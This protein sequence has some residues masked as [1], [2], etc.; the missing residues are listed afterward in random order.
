MTNPVIRVNKTKIFSAALLYA[1]DPGAR[2]P[3]IFLV[4][5]TDSRVF[6]CQLVTDDSAAVFR[7]V[8]HQ[9]NFK[10]PER[11]LHNGTDTL[12]YVVFRSVDRNDDTDLRH[13]IPSRIL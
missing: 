5:Y 1:P 10:V 3:A 9:Y 2:E 12:F 6:S 11:L 7:S 8:V 4:N 13:S